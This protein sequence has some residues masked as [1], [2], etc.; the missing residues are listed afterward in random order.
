MAPAF[1][2]PALAAPFRR[3]DVGKRLGIAFFRATFQTALPRISPPPVCDRAHGDHRSAQPTEISPV[4]RSPAAPRPSAHLA[5]HQ[6]G[7][8]SGWAV[9]ANA[10][11]WLI[12]D[13][14][15]AFRCCN[16]K[17]LAL[18]LIALRNSIVVQLKVCGYKRRI[19]RSASHA[20][21]CGNG[22]DNNQPRWAG[23]G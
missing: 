15:I 13:Q 10:A 12:K 5:F 1:Q 2:W 22:T 6:G 3:R 17:A 20:V 8:V 14:E 7:D 11:G 4:R 16:V 21:L 19:K 9:T 23:S 18:L